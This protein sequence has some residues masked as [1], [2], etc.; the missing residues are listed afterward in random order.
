MIKHQ[1]TNCNVL[2]TPSNVCLF[3]QLVA[4]NDVMRVHARGVKY[5]QGVRIRHIIVN[6]TIPQF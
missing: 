5:W 1:H 3:S 6:G 2:L 4:L